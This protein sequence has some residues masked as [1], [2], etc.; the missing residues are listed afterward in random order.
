MRTIAIAL[1]LGLAA[2]SGEKA[3]PQPSGTP[4]SELI[5]PAATIT[6]SEAPGAARTGSDTG[7]AVSAIPAPLRGRWGLV[8][9]DCTTARGDEKGLIAISANE[10]KF[11]ESVARLKTATS[12][13]AAAIDATFAFSG[14]GMDWTRRITMAT[15]DGGKTMNLEEFGDDAPA[16]KRVYTKC[17]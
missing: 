5:A 13:S 15:S 7:A 2:C 17:Q 9:A 14:E 11:Y 10:L 6:P 12:G 8:P 3:D 1:V 4:D 16:G